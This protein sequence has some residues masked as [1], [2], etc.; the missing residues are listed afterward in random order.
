M[1]LETEKYLYDIV[2]AASSATNH[3]EPTKMKG[4]RSDSVPMA[5]Y[6]SKGKR[7]F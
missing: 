5:Q 1:K 3:L 4:H 2:R 7:W 6:I